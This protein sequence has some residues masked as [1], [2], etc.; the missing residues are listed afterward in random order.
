MAIGTA[1]RL[2]EV[3]RKRRYRGPAHSVWW[4]ILPAGALYAFAVIIPSVQG[5][6]FGF[7]DWD[8]ISPNPD[9]VGFDQ[10]TRIWSDPNGMTAIK[11][12]LLIAFAVT[13]VQNVAGLLV[14][15]GLN[16]VIKSRNILR[17]LIFAP[18]VITS[19]AVGFLWKNL[20]TPD[21]GINQGLEAIGLGA[22]RENWLGD[23]NVAIWAI[24]VV[25]IWQNVGYS[26]VIFLAGLQGIPEEILEA[27]AID[28][29]GPIRRFWSVVRPLL[30]P[31]ITINLMLS[32]IGGLKLFDQVFV[33]TQGGPGGATNTISTLIYSNAFQLGRFAYGAALAVVLTIFVAVVSAI[34]YKVLAAQEN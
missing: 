11:N 12:T 34:Q 32:L 8:G 10:F 6:L 29:A 19:I 23:P 28:G 18:V 22:L 33:M 26:M 3:P 21:G 9:W 4:F 25:I 7:T 13:V 30:A 31:A 1:V 5:G 20:F 15:L 14:A 24:I 16:T 17:V 2:K 27:A